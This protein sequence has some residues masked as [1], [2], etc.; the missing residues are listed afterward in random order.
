MLEKAITFEDIIKDSLIN[1]MEGSSLYAFTKEV[2]VDTVK[3]GDKLEIDDI[4]K[5]FTQT[6][7]DVTVED[8]QVQERI[9]FNAVGVSPI[10]KLITSKWL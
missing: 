1:P 10:N 6:V 3:V 4:H 7:D 8:S 9:G 5:S 2:E